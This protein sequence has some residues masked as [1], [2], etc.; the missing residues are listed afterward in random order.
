MKK[1]SLLLTLLLIVGCITVLSQTT[2][3]INF[4]RGA[5]SAIVFGSLYNYKSERTYLLRV[6]EGQTIYTEQLKPSSSLKYV[7]IYITDP[8]GNPV[9][10]SDASCNDRRDISP[11]TPGD[12]QIRIVEC[13]KADPWTGRFRFKVSVR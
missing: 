9:G 13:Q 3:R 5:Y 11:T 12:Y 8:N 4:R 7:T 10:D 1:T 6:R 2:S